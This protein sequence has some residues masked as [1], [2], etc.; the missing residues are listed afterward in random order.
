MKTLLTFFICCVASLNAFSQIV[1]VRLT[2]TGGN[3]YNDSTIIRFSPTASSGILQT[4]DSLKVFSTNPQANSLSSVS[5]TTDLS[6]NTLPSTTYT[7]PLRVKVAG[8]GKYII[9][10]DTNISLPAGFCLYLEDLSNGITTDMGNSLAYSYQ[11]IIEDTTIAPRF[12]LHVGRPSLMAQVSPDCSYKQNGQAIVSG[13]GSGPW[14]ITWKD[15]FNNTLVTHTNVTSSDTLANL[16][17]GKYIFEIAGNNGFCNILI[18]SIVIV[19]PAPIS[20]NPAITNLTCQGTKGT[21]NA[22]NTSGGTAPYS[23]QWSNGSFQSVISNLSPGVFTLMITDAKG[24]Q[25]TGYY[26]IQKLSNLSVNFTASADTVSM[27]NATINFSNL[28]TGHNTVSWNFGDGSASSQ[29]VNPSHTYLQAGT[30]TVELSASDNYCMEN[31]KKVIHVINSIGME[32]AVLSTGNVSMIN[33]PEG[34]FVSFNLQ[35]EQEANIEVYSIEGKLVSQKQVNAFKNTESV[36]LGNA[37][38][39]YIVSVIANGSHLVKKVIK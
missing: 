5:Y 16:A 30:F 19:A 20:S 34:T 29:A 35:T 39:V 23:Y 33:T 15:A 12:V 38:G 6:Y 17:P 31:Y 4:E 22:S 11:C 24:C 1:T 2:L 27:P 25:D 28:T 36:E 13:E 14:D 7:V 21:I 10:R 9:T 3:N 26:S 32:E 8:T 37:S 18:D